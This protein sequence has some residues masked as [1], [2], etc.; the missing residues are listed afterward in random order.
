MDSTYLDLAQRLQAIID[1]A[2]DGILT[3]DSEGSIE[4][5]NFAACDIFGYNQSELLGKN[6]KMLMPEPDKSKHDQYISNYHNT[7]KPKIIGIGREVTGL[8][9]SGDLFPLRLA[10]SEVVLN[11]R[12]IFT[13]IVHD[14]TEYNQAKSEIISLN[15]DLEKKVSERTYEIEEVVNKLLKTNRNLESEILERKYAED[16]LVKQ[17]IELKT[18]LEK[19]KEFGDLKSRFV[20]MAS[21]EFRTPLATIL[22]SASLIQRYELSEQQTSRLKHVDRIKSAVNNLTGILNDFLSLSKL[23][24]GK[25]TANFTMINVP[26]IVQS[27]IDD[28]KGILKPDQKF[29]VSI[30]GEVIPILSDAQLLKNI[31]FNLMSNAIKYSD[32][33]ILVS[34][35]FKEDLVIE[36]QDF[37]IGIPENDQKHLFDRFFRASNVSNIQGT[38][39]GLHIIKQ[40]LSLIEGK[41]SLVSEY[42]KGTTFTITIPIKIQ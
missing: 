9:K 14:L 22:S 37:G 32:D 41:I 34:V 40:Y 13:G 7:R 10:V 28:L 21:H 17:G 39:L 15:K 20:S 29:E 11:N 24:E 18:A 5:V 4:S 38:G 26:E 3:I 6:V 27:A 19:E 2:T 1:M 31:L 16:Q 30:T 35:A 33:V 36:V 42:H 25:L 8:K 23:E 12:I